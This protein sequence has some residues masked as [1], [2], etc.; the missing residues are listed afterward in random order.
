[1]SE[2]ESD[3]CS[4]PEKTKRRRGESSKTYS[5]EKQNFGDEWITNTD[6]SDWLLP[7]HNNKLLAKCKLCITE[8]TAE[9]S[10]IKKHSQT[11]KTF[12]FDQF[13]LVEQTK[14]AEILLSSFISEHNLPFNVSDHLVKTCNA[15]YPDSKI[16]SNIPLACTKSTA[17]VSNVIGLYSLE[18]LTNVLQKTLFS[19]IID[20]S[21]NL[22]EDIESDKGATGQKIFDEVIKAFTDSKIPLDN[23]IEFASDGCNT[24][25]GASNSATSR[26]KEFLP[27]FV[28]LLNILLVLLFFCILKIQMAENTGI[29]FKTNYF[30]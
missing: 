21:T 23:L 17:L 3:N 15:A 11:K 5:H 7:V 13:K 29:D 8:M 22:F 14:K 12:K 26:L 24:M 9:L 25:F 30:I 2:N 4:T 19:V 27:G 6:Y 1:M 18:Q 10:V 20:E 28:L 16:C